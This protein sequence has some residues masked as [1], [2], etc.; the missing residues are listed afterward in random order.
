M[1]QIP[2]PAAKKGKNLV[3]PAQLVN[4]LPGINMVK[5]DV[6]EEAKK[7]PTVKHFLET[8]IE[9]NPAPEARQERAGQRH[10][11]ELPPLPDECPLASC[12]PAQAKALIR[13]TFD[14]G[15][16]KAWQDEETRGEV[17]RDIAE[18]I[19]ALEHPAEVKNPGAV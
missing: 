15:L 10:L 17:R 8:D 6:W 2:V 9:H 16:L 7:N 3:A 11:I 13:D 19:K 18:A 1:I 14:V 12:T 4:L 5:Q